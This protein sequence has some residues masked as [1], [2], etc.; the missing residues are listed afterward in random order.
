MFGGVIAFTAS[1]FLIDFV[2]FY[3]QTMEI[4]L[5]GIWSMIMLG[6]LLG[7]AISLGTKRQTPEE[8]LLIGAI[9]FWFAYQAVN[10][11]LGYYAAWIHPVNLP[12][13]WAD[14]LAITAIGAVGCMI[15][16]Y[17]LNGW[18]GMLFLFVV[19][20]FSVGL[21]AALSLNLMNYIGLHANLQLFFTP[22]R[23]GLFSFALRSLSGAAVWCIAWYFYPSARLARDDE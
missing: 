17:R 23:I 13:P 19:G 12:Y 9:G 6:A 22:I 15:L 5:V 7:I 1:S 10:F 4:E 2:P 11:A 14:I 20:A 3:T 18:H 8:L 21:G 16:G